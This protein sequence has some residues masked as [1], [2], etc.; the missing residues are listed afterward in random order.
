VQRHVRGQAK[1]R[2]VS[3]TLYGTAGR[4]ST[5]LRQVFFGFWSM[6]PAMTGYPV[7]RERN[8]FNGCLLD[9]WQVI[10]KQIVKKFFVGCIKGY[11]YLISPLFPPSCRFTPTCSDYAI[12]AIETHG[13]LRGVVLALW[14]IL[15]CHPFAKGGH[16]P[17]R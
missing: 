17:V 5:I 14:R 10:I 8:R 16:D 13:V 11:Q 6:G 15:R 7:Y 2:F 3:G 12:Q 1:N 4:P 9:H